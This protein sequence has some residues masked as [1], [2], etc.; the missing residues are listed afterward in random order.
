MSISS[1]RGVT[2][3]SFTKEW[4]EDLVRALWLGLGGRTVDLE[5]YLRRI[6]PKWEGEAPDLTQRLYDLLAQSPQPGSPLRRVTPTSEQ[7]VADG[8]TTPFHMATATNDD[9]LRFEDPV[10]LPVEPVWPPNIAAELNSI[11]RERE[12]APELAKAGLKPTHTVIFTGL[13]GVGKTLAARWL[14]RELGLPLAVL[15]L[16]SVMS[17][18]LGRTGANLRQVI[19]YASQQR[20]VL[21]LDELDAI[22]KRRDDNSDIGELKRLVTVLLQ[23]LDAWS[24]DA[25]LVAATNHEDLIDPAVWRRFERRIAFPLPEAAQQDELLHR[26][27][28]DAW[29]ALPLGTRIGVSAAATRLSP[30]DVTQIALRTKREMVVGSGRFEATLLANLSGAVASLSLAE[31]RRVGLDLKRLKIGQREINRLTGLA[32]ETIRSLQTK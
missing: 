6:L 25:L 1:K 10:V 4:A 11:I 2:K 24:S 29:K 12:A 17:S 5:Q 23:E 16:G 30:A 31:R 18:F 15:N 7:R 3:N 13:P 28:G 21:L 9:L 20:C 27:L 19:A 14:A 22:A 26:L 32:R 8:N